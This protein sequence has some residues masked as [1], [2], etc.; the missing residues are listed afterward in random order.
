MRDIDSHIKSIPG[1]YYYQRYV[2]DMVVLIYP[3]DSTIT[4]KDYYDYI[5]K[6]VHAKGLELHTGSEENKT[7][8]IDSRKMSVI[9]FCYLG[10]RIRM[11]K[12][13]RFLPYLMINTVIMRN[14]YIKLSELSSTIYQMRSDKE[15]L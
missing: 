12:G 4:P 2:D 11:R 5:Y 6:I 13:K 9:S 15:V 7:I 1:V 8:L 3:K 10:Y 14:G